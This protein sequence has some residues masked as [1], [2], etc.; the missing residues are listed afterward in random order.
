MDENEIRELVLDV[1]QE[2]L[3]SFTIS[4]TE[5]LDSIVEKLDQIGQQ[6]EDWKL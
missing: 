6:G 5:R 1:V 2:A 3:D 4:L